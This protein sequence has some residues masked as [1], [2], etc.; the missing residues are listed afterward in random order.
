GDSRWFVKR[1]MLYLLGECNREEVLPH[2]RPYARHENRKV[3]FEAVRCLLNS[4]DGYGLEAVKDY[5][6][7]ES[8]ESVE[9]GIALAG[10][11]RIKKVVPDLIQLLKKRRIGGTDAY[12]KIPIVK[13]LGEIG[14]PRALD[15]LREVL[16]GKSLFFKGVTEK[17]KEEI[18]RTLRNYPYSAIR[19]F[20][21]AGM[22][23]KSEYIR[24][25]SLRLSRT[26]A[27]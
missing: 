25:E 14:D 1:N 9:Q 22:K 21:E 24:E 8:R 20:I 4:M 19:D 13:A 11:Y 2:I 16:S 18:Y 23:S 17:L 15:A 6:S 10:A 12:E 3:S 26:K 5:L 27:D 7:S